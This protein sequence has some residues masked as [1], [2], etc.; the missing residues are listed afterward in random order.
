MAWNVDQIY[1]YM[2]LLVRKNQSGSISSTEF[3]NTWNS[4]QSAMHTDLVGKWQA[5]AAGRVGAGN[6]GFVENELITTKMAPFTV[7]T[8][9]TIAA[10]QATKPAD[11]VYTLA[12]RINDTKV[13][14]VNHDQIWAVKQDVIDP[15]S[16]T[17]DSYYY[18]EYLDYYSFLPTT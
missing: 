12:L 11:F 7:P 3:F 13:F 8:T 18:T 5:A 10:G 2:R 16:I 6:Q 9:L 15:P 1:G 17:D 14:K 4:E